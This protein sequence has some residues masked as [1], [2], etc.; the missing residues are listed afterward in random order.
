MKLS[1]FKS[2]VDKLK[3]SNFVCNKFNNEIKNIY[4]SIFF[5]LAL[6]VNVDSSMTRQVYVSAI[7]KLYP[8]LN[9]SIPMPNYKIWAGIYDTLK[10]R[11][12]NDVTNPALEFSANRLYLN[13]DDPIWQ[14][15]NINM[16]DYDKDNGKNKVIS[17]LLK[18]RRN[19]YKGMLGNT[20]QPYYVDKVLSILSLALKNV[21]TDRVPIFVSSVNNYTKRVKIYIENGS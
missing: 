18:K 8:L 9:M 12:I 4:A 21:G 5:Y 10:D 2:R 13:S 1:E 15:E 11:N 6:E 3:N 7:N 16:T 20:Y 17:A 14:L 19:E